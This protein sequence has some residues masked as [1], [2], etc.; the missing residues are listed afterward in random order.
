MTPFAPKSRS[1]YVF[2]VV[3]YHL[4]QRKPQPNALLNS[5]LDL[6][7]TL[8]TGFDLKGVRCHPEWP[9]VFGPPMPIVDEMRLYNWL[10]NFTPLRIRLEDGQFKKMGW[11]AT[12]V[13]NRKAAGL[14]VWNIKDAKNSR[15]WC[16]YKEPYRTACEQ[17]EEINQPLI[18]DQAIA[19]YLR[20]NPVTEDMGKFGVPQDKYRYKFYGH[21]SMEVDQWRMEYRIK[22][23]NG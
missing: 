6:M 23:Y 16:F 19:D 22:P 2:K 8:Q 9:L 20:R 12:Y 11:S 15:W 1:D 4:D 7:A 5:L 3:R 13:K 17:L 21:A 14:P 18:N 10:A